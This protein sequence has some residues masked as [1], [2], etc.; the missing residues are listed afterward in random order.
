MMHIDPGRVINIASVAGLDPVADGTSLGESD[1]GLWSYNTSKAAAIVGLR[2]F[3][4][5]K[6]HHKRLTI[7]MSH[8]TSPNHSRQHSQLNTSPSTLFAR[9]Y[10]RVK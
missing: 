4:L 6:Y 2:L 10:T 7:L 5:K 3:T 8:S 1:H 9:V